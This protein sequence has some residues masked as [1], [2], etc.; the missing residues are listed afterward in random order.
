LLR[1]QGY[2]LVFMICMRKLDNNRF[3]LKS[4]FLVKVKNPGM[5]KDRW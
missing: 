2:R 3:F 4:P 1:I 5:K